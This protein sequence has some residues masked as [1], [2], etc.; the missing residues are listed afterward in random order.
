MSD[1]AIF[2][3]LPELTE[4]IGVEHVKGF[5]DRVEQISLEQ[6]SVLV[7]DQAPMDAFYLLLEG[8]LALSIEVDGH[9]IQ[10]GEL[11]PG[12]WIGEVAFLNGTFIACT[13]V[14]AASEAKLAR[15]T[16]Q[17]FEAMLAEDPMLAC[18]LMHGFILMLIR[19]L[20]ATANDPVLDPDGQLH[21]Y[22][23]MSVP[24]EALAPHKHSVLDFLKGLFGAR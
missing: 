14:S 17:D 1:E 2:A 23:D 11:S 18:R 3:H 4:Q 16:Y 21:I 9:T 22:A 15:L 6:G 20:R 8:R 7:R 12:N 13:T 5:V 24:W 19:R 10:L